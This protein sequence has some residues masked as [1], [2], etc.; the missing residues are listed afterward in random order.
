MLTKWFITYA[1]VTE[2]SL[3]YLVSQPGTFTVLV[4]WEWEELV[5]FIMLWVHI[6]IIYNVNADV[7]QNTTGYKWQ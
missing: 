5:W 4:A 2:K 1:N 7:M 6:Y 3:L